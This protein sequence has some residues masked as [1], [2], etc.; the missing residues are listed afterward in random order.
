MSLHP[1]FLHLLCAAVHPS[2]SFRLIRK[3]TCYVCKRSV[4]VHLSIIH[5]CNPEKIPKRMQIIRSRLLCT[6]R[7]MASSYMSEEAPLAQRFFLCVWV[8]CVLDERGLRNSGTW[9]GRTWSRTYAR[10]AIASVDLPLYEKDTD[11][12][13]AP[14]KKSMITTSVVTSSQATVLLFS[15]NPCIFDWLFSCD[16]P[17][18]VECCG[19]KFHTAE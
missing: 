9:S 5:R 19:T 10:G 8:R 3:H 12:E 17:H 16:C 7:S 1:L 2:L 15:S 18:H 6:T 13:K 14:Y 11:R 4:S